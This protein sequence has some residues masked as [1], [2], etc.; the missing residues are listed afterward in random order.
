MPSPNGVF[1]DGAL[2]LYQLTN[3]VEYIEKAMDVILS[4]L[5]SVSQ[6]MNSQNILVGGVSILADA[7]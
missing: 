2:E 7:N 1:I 6:S 3:G 4:F 5:S